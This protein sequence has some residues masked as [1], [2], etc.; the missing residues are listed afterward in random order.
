M[1][2]ILVV[3]PNWIGD[4]LLA[5]PLLARLAHRLPGVA[6]DAFAPAWTAPV[7]RR[8]PEIS[9]VIE[10]PF[11]HGGL[12]LRER[13]RIGRGLRVSG[14]EQAY[15]LPNS[16]KSA[17]VPFFADIPLRVGYVGESRYGLINI[18]HRLKAK[19]VPLMA[20]RYAQLA[21]VP[22]KPLERPLLTSRLV[23]DEANLVITLARLGVDR[24]RPIVAFCPGAEYGPAKRWPAR[25]FATLARQLAGRGRSV[26][27]V[28][29]QKDAYAGAEIA[30][31]SD[32]AA[33]NLCGRTDLASAIDL[34]SAAQLVISNDSGLMHVAAALGRPLVALY[35]SSSADHTP[36]LSNGNR[37]PRIV[38]L[39]GVECSPCF[40][41]E[42]PLGHFRCMNDLTPERVM[43]D[44]EAIE[45]TA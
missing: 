37:L 1:S 33:T 12:Q 19:Q 20:D 31:L 26:W 44:I 30:R 16:F 23:V 11:G 35:G 43:G 34:L 7:L 42:C 3:A 10:S 24:R 38:K 17:L 27:L 18:A 6:I 39:E 29:S 32:G 13:L 2:R 25:H 15:V 14:Y 8:M 21:E 45:A 36:P 5:Q 9:E 22:G 41:R 28:G 4:T 40:K